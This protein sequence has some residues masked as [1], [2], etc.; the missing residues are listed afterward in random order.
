MPTTA[1]PTSGAIQIDALMR[2]A[3]RVEHLN[4]EAG[5]IGDG[6]LASLVED[7]RQ[8]LAFTADLPATAA[9]TLHTFAAAFSLW[10]QT[11]R[12]DPGAFLTDEE[13]RAMELADYGE[14]CAVHFTALLRQVRTPA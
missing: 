5:A 12:D 2:L 14:R 10:E 8:A 7:A 4:P 9:N 11:Y 3:H 13:T 1:T 6:M